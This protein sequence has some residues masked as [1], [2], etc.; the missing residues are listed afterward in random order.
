MLRSGICL[1]KV[2][3]H[4]PHVIDTFECDQHV[5]SSTL[6]RLL[7]EEIRNFECEFKFNRRREIS[8]KASKVVVRMHA[9]K[10]AGTFSGPRR[11]M[12]PQRTVTAN[13]SAYV[14][15]SA[16]HFKRPHFIVQRRTICVLHTLPSRPHLLATETPTLLTCFRRLSCA[17][18]AAYRAVR[19]IS[20]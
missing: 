13:H 2:L 19:N 20:M 3:Q 6:A 7:M 18:V 17:P 5:P 8:T 10:A 12:H 9:R 15:R 14:T 4:S 16:C 1:M 11:Q